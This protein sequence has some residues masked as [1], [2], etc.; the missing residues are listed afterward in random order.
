MAAVNQIQHSQL[1][2]VKDLL[3][4]VFQEILT[5]VNT[6]LLSPLI[7]VIFDGPAYNERNEWT[8]LPA[9]R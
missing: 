7:L 4:N 3:T 6:R 5:L 2:F 9:L 8:N 1:T